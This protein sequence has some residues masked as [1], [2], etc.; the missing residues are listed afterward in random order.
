MFSMLIVCRSPIFLS[1]GS[2]SQWWAQPSCCQQHLLFHQPRD[3]AQTRAASAESR[4]YVCTPNYAKFRWRKVEKDKGAERHGH[5]GVSRW[6]GQAAP[7]LTCGQRATVWPPGPGKSTSQ[8]APACWSQTCEWARW[9]PRVGNQCRPHRRPQRYGDSRHWRCRWNKDNTSLFRGK[10]QDRFSS[11][12]QHWS[13]DA[14][15][16]RAAD[17][18]KP[19]DATWINMSQ[20]SPKHRATITLRKKPQTSEKMSESYFIINWTA[21]KTP[22]VI[23]IPQSL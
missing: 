1:A 13:L 8:P 9:N 3:R 20:Q 6:R 23:K 14:V 22:T 17:T 11:A 7:I 4:E 5:P 12:D 10:L 19:R 21:R 16:N 18:Q 15:E 2:D